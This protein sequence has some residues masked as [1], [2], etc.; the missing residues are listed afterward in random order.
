MIGEVAAA[1]LEDGEAYL[2]Y[3]TFDDDWAMWERALDGTR[4]I[5]VVTWKGG[6][7]TDDR[8]HAAAWTTDRYQF[9]PLDNDQAA[10]TEMAARH[11]TYA[12]WCGW[13]KRQVT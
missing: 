5:L 12:A 1:S 7:R 6:V 2:T 4:D 10:A 8:Y 9:F 13:V 3:D 11:M